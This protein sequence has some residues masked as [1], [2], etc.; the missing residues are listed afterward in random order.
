[1]FNLMKGN[2]LFTWEG[3]QNIPLPSILLL[4]SYNYV[5]NFEIGTKVKKHIFRKINIQYR[6]LILLLIGDVRFSSA[7]TANFF[8]KLAADLKLL[9]KE[10]CLRLMSSVFS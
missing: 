8:L 5:G 9:T 7:K 4:P 1:M 10:Q 2:P 6:L 3:G